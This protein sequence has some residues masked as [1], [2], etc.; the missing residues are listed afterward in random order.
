MPFKIDAGGDSKQYTTHVLI[1]PLFVEFML[2][3]RKFPGW[4][5]GGWV[6]T[7]MHYTHF[8]TGEKLKSKFSQ[9]TAKF[10]NNGENVGSKIRLLDA[11]ENI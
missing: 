9:G 10:I 11:D 2:F 3:I 5:V 1:R 6:I 4:T 7:I 8:S